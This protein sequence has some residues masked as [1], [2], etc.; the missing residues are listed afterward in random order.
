LKGIAG[1][2]IQTTLVALANNFRMILRKPR[3]F[4]IEIFVGIRGPL[5]VESTASL[6]ADVL[7]QYFRDDSQD[8]GD[9]TMSMPGD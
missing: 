2:Q 3:I 9:R 4:C 1:D 7:K 5:W 8:P 6:L